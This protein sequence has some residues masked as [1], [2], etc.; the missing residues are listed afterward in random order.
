MKGGVTKRRWSASEIEYLMQ[1]YP[2]KDN[3]SLANDMGRTEVALRTKAYKLGVK[4]GD[5]RSNKPNLTPSPSLSYIIGVVFGDG[6]PNMATRKTG[7]TNYNIDLFVTDKDFTDAFNDAL[8]Q[9]LGRRYAV[10]LY[11]DRYQVRG[12]S[13][14]LYFL[15]KDRDLD[16]LKEFVDPF[17]A[18]FIRG[19]ADSEG[20]I[21]VY[22]NNGYKGARLGLCNTN[23]EVMPFIEML[24]QKFGIRTHSSEHPPGR[25]SIKRDGSLI[26]S[27]K[28]LYRIVI[29]DKASLKIF[30]EEVGFSIGRKQEK[31]MEA[32]R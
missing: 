32:V 16:S 19:F 2:H 4:R 11:G 26:T 6:S 29:H 22:S 15:L 5:W 23:H 3:L 25:T 28:L 27:R 10:Q 13:K 1:N 21:G 9:I 24:L 12:Q 8:Y 17:P 30:A 7:R 14:T 18:D 20:S 31:L